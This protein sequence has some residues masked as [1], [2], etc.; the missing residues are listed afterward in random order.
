M[1]TPPSN[2]QP[3]RPL[4]KVRWLA[5]FPKSGN[6][7]V[8]AFLANLLAPQGR[9]LTL[10]E[11]SS[12]PFYT[13]A[14]PNDHVEKEYFGKAHRPYS[15]ERHGTKPAIYIVRDP[16]DVVP[17]CASFF[18]VSIPRMAEEV[19]KDWPRHVQS[20]VGHAS[21][22]IRY[23]DM[24]RHFHTLAQ[25]LSVPS[26][27]ESVVTAIS[28]KTRPRTASPKPRRSRRRSFGR[29]RRGVGVR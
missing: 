25:H 17:S 8:R 10:Q 6:T 2:T 1:T 27:F 20:W 23:E 12:M 13:D 21:L 18:G 19:A 24:P 16:V 15:E 9:P 14:K 26:D 29:G 7:W 11:I 5:S 28:S 4:S 3:I 22:F